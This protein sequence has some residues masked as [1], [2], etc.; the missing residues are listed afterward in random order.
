MIKFCKIQLLFLKFLVNMG[1]RVQNILV[2][3]YT[4]FQKILLTEFLS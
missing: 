4:V 2:H 1:Y 3:L